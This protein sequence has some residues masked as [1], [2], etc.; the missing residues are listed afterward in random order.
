MIKPLLS[1]T[2]PVS[3]FTGGEAVLRRFYLNFFLLVFTNW[4]MAP[5]VYSKLYWRNSILSGVFS[6]DTRLS[7]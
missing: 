5:A 3:R 6:R 7:A 1:V 2:K 4:P